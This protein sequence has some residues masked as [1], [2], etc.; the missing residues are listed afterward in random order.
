MTISDD[1]RTSL[2]D[3]LDEAFARRHGAGT[4]LLRQADAIAHAARAAAERFRAGGRL[5]AFGTGLAAADAQHVAVEF[6]HPVI[7]GT[8]ALPALALTGDA[9]APAAGREAADPGEVFAAAL[10]VQGA[11][12]DIALG[13]SADGGCVSVTRGLQA[14][15]GLGMLTIALSGG[16]P[17]AAVPAAARHRIVVGHADVLPTREALVTAYHILWEL[18]HCFL[19]EAARRAR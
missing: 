18:T 7:V 19:G 8:R 9:P 1:T 15:T 12:R 3:V 11:S 4:T 13:L 6:L 10:R 5:L 17:G 16:A 2:V 14:A